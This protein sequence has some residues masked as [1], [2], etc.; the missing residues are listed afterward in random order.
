MSKRKEPSP[1]TEA[2]ESARN[3]FEDEESALRSEIRTMKIQRA[4][5]AEEKATFESKLRAEKDKFMREL[6]DK[7]RHFQEE[8]SA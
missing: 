4:M 6:R 2:T 1:P 7:E 3:A 5:L 8:W